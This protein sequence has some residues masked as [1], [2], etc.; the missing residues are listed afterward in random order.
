MIEN[1]YDIRTV[2]ELMGHD[3]VETTMIYLHVVQKGLGAV[4]PL[5]KLKGHTPPPNSGLKSPNWPIPPTGSDSSAPT[6]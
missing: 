5:D 4:S 1:G 6:R 2:Q 3:S